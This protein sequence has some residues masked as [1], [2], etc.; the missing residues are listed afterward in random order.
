MELTLEEEN[1]KTVDKLLLPFRKFKD[2]FKSACK[3]GKAA[4]LIQCIL[5]GFGPLLLGQ[6]ELGLLFVVLIYGLSF[7]FGFILAGF[8]GHTILISATTFVV[9]SLILIAAIVALWYAT[10]N[11]TVRLVE[12]LNKNEKIFKSFI[13]EAIVKFIFSIVDWFKEFGIQFKAGDKKVKTLLPLSFFTFGIPLIVFG[14]VV[15]GIALFSVQL[16][17]ILYLVARGFLDLIDFFTLHVKIKDA[18]PTLVYGVIALVVVLLLIYFYIVSIKSTLKAAR[19]YNEKR[20][21]TNF[22]KQLFNVIDKNFYVTSLIVPI[23]GALVFT[24]IPLTFMI[25]SAFTNY[26]YKD[27]E[28]GM[29][30]TSFLDWAGFSSFERVFARTGNFQDLLSV[31][32]WTMIWALLATFTCFFGGL[33]L[34]MLINKKTVKFKVIYRSLF[35]VSM[36]MPQFVSLL[37]MHS[38]FDD[39]GP[40]HQFL[41]SLG[42]VDPNVPMNLWAGSASSAF[43]ARMLIIII[44]MWVGIPYYMLLMSG[45]LI[46]IPKGYYEAAKIAGASRWQ[47]FKRITF[48]N[49][50]FMTAPMLITSFVNNINNFNVIWFLTKGGPAGD[51]GGTAQET[52][53][54]ITWLYKLTMT[55][56]KDY[57]FGAAIGIIMFIITATLSLVVLHRSSSYKNEEEYR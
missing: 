18:N 40:L 15:K 24:I 25:L 20:L 42:W 52:D 28:G 26:T 49:I 5:L 16:L 13:Y 22:K 23:L 54:L 21:G 17:G 46:N 57:N 56:D 45:L 32:S 50:M 43:T 37:V 48:P 2:V 8:I 55:G 27:V 19:E 47:Q 30:D 51:R 33:L 38:F 12:K 6:I 35:V 11:R 36:A 44:N 14:E 39:Y 31:F 9:V 10:F 34:A 41:G 1:L 4:M 7:G 53:I 29:Y 3:Y